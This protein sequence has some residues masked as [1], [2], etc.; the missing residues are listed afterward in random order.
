MLEQIKNIDIADKTEQQDVTEC[1][2]SIHH[3]VESADPQKSVIRKAF[4]ALKSIPAI[5]AEKAVE[6]GVE[7]VLAAL[8]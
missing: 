8:I 7:H 6:L 4:R 3:E 2:N 5:I 1:V